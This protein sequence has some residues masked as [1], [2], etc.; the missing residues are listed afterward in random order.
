LNRCKEAAAVIAK[1]PAGRTGLGQL[2]RS[3]RVLDMPSIRLVL[4][5]ACVIAIA[6]AQ[7]QTI[8]NLVVDSTDH[9]MLEALVIRL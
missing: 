2:K 4:V 8:V 9:E 5:I 3:L 6:Q 7:T 1:V